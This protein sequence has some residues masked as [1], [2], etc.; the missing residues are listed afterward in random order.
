MEH[1][2][3]GVGWAQRGHCLGIEKDGLHARAAVVDAQHVPVAVEHQRGIRLL[4]AQDEV[5]RAADLGQGRRL[6]AGRPVDGRVAGRREQVVAVA[7][8]HVERPRQQQ[9][10][11]ATGLRPARFDEAQ[12]ARG[13]AGL[14]REVELAEAPPGAP[15]A[16]ERPEADLA[17]RGDGVHAGD[18]TPPSASPKLPGR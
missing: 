8:R 18:S 12:V 1:E 14:H 9:D 5:E 13:H 4:L 7:Q 17:Q 3:H 15:A 11:L 10:H 16:Q 6:Q 2:A